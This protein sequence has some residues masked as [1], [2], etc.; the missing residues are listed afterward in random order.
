MHIEEFEDEYVVTLF[1]E[2]MLMQLLL[3]RLIDAAVSLA[4]LIALFPLMAGGCDSDQADQP[5]AG[6]FRRRTA[7]E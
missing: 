3:K 4:V 2:Q 1:R 6:V 7:W 5:R